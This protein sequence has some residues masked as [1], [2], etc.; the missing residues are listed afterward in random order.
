MKREEYATN[1]AQ[2]PK[3]FIGLQPNAAHWAC[4]R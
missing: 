2:S 1:L 4:A 3:K